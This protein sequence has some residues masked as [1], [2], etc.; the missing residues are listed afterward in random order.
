MP[1]FI[2]NFVRNILVLYL[3]IFGLWYFQMSFRIYC[4]CSMSQFNKHKPQ[5]YNEY[6]MKIKNN[7]Q[8][9]LFPKHQKYNST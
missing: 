2:S 6:K 5:F 9:K 1:D 4:V 7:T 8:D 3:Y